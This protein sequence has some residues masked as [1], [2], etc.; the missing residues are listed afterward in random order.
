MLNDP[1]NIYFSYIIFGML[2]FILSAVAVKIVT[3]VLFG[4][5]REVYLTR[6]SKALSEVVKSS[7]TYRPPTNNTDD[8]R[9][10]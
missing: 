8:E 6:V 10:N 9:P 7:A 2:A 4:T 5:I 1:V 3:V